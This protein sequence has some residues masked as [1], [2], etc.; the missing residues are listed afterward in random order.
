MD[1]R[2]SEVQALVSLGRDDQSQVDMRMRM[3]MRSFGAL[4]EQS[5][6]GCKIALQLSGLWKLCRE[7]FGL[8]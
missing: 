4:M 3:R 2:R 8:V 6:L 1:G 7:I 5:D